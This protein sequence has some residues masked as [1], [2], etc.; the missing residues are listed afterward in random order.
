MKMSTFVT[1]A[2][3]KLDTEGIKGLELVAV[4]HTIGQFSR[5]WIYP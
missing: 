5:Q 3:A 2:K 4:R 1:L